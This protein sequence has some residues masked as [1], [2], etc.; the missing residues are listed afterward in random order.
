MGNSNTTLLWLLPEPSQEINEPQHRVKLIKLSQQERL[1]G[2]LCRL[3]GA[4]PYRGW[5]T[6][7]KAGKGHSR[8]AQDKAMFRGETKG[9]ERE[10]RLSLELFIIIKHHF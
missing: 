3:S 2:A 7:W 8:F 5:D 1:S 6:I 4:T 10:E 9:R